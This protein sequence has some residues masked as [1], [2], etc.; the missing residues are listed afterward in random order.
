MSTPDTL[1]DTTPH[2]LLPSKDINRELWLLFAQWRGPKLY[3]S[4]HLHYRAGMRT[5]NLVFSHRSVFLL[6]VQVGLF[7]Q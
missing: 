4:S 5:F 1:M 2:I 7:S 3:F 6:P